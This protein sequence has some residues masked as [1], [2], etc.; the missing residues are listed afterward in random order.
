MAE[1]SLTSNHLLQSSSLA[2]HQRDLHSY[3]FL[4]M[5]NAFGP[6]FRFGAGLF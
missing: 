2:S 5:P 1:Q 4:T 3:A 6:R